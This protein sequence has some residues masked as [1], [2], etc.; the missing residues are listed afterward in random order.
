MSQTSGTWQYDS[1]RGLIYEMFLLLK[2]SVNWMKSKPI[3]LTF[4]KALVKVCK[5]FI[6][7][8]RL[9]EIDQNCYC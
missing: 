6:S 1:C 8:V 4:E 9:Y 7:R 3:D 2:Y 5:V